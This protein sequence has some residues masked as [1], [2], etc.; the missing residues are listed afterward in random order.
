MISLTDEQILA[1]LVAVVAGRESFYYEP[2]LVDDAST[3]VYFGEDGAPSCIIGHVL[4]R[5]GITLAD[6]Q[7]DNP[8]LGA[9]DYNDAGIN[10]LLGIRLFACSDAAASALF[11]AQRMQDIGH[12]WGE[13]LTAAEETM[14]EMSEELTILRRSLV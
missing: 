12:S 2:P 1:D 11:N 4:A 6:L 8:H 5:H 10:M 14:L 13:A 9:R 7:R 3:C